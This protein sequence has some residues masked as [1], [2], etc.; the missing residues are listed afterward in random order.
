MRHLLKFLK[1]KI[2][3][4]NFKNADYS[5]TKSYIFGSSFAHIF[6]EAYL[7]KKSKL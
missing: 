2:R 3:F 5:R 1:K 7:L 4:I 6:G